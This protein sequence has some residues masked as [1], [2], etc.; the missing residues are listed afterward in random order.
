[1]ASDSPF[2]PSGGT[3]ANVAAAQT[4]A[5]RLAAERQ[6]S[7][8]KTW[9][10]PGA[11]SAA[12]PAAG[13]G[14]SM[15]GDLQTENQLLR[16]ALA[17]TEALRAKYHDLYEH[18]PVGYFTLSHTGEVLEMNL[19]A[20]RLLGQA[21]EKLVGHQMREFF[22][23]SSLANFELFM[24]TVRQS[25]EEIFAHSLTVRRKLQMPL[26]VNMQARTVDD[27]ARGRS[28]IRLTMMDVT[29][30]KNAREDAIHAIGKVSGFG[31]L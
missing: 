28:K 12:T 10:T 9:L 29:E 18:A 7:A 20:A 16:E 24:T 17:C 2:T 6:L 1:M 3:F 23:N 27:S 14:T 8:R 26:Y 15:G 22:S 13:E 19:C 25:H 30:L 4:E 5:L 21:R 31:S 11:E